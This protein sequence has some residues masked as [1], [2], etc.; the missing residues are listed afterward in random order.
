MTEE[1]LIRKLVALAGAPVFWE[2]GNGKK[3]INGIE[4]V[5]NKKLT[6]EKVAVAKAAWCHG[7]SADPE[8]VYEISKASLEDERGRTDD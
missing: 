8:E 4:E 5:K 3:V 6:D 2:R 7:F 1:R